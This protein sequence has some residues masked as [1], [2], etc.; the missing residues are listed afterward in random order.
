MLPFLSKE[1][2]SAG[3]GEPS[4]A[5]TISNGSPSI[6][7]KHCLLSMPH[8]SV[9]GRR[10]ADDTWRLAMW[11][12][13]TGTRDK[14]KHDRDV[15]WRPMNIDRDWKTVDRLI[16]HTQTSSSVFECIS[17][18][19]CR[20]SLSSCSHRSTRSNRAWLR[21]NRVSNKTFWFHCNQE[22]QKGQRERTRTKLIRY[23]SMM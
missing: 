2:S 3:R 21:I 12:C 18:A 20:S 16:N 5:Q 8:K 11:I 6:I 19:G 4:A 15:Q 13:C 9:L 14:R 1:T 10:D 23:R 22:Q 17:P 7:T